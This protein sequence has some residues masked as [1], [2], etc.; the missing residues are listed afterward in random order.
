MKISVPTLLVD[1]RKC[2]IRL[3]Q[4][5]LRLLGCP[6][7][8]QLLVN[9]D[10][11]VI[12]L[13]LCDTSDVRAHHQKR[14]DEALELYSRPLLRQLLLCGC[15]NPAGVYKLYGAAVPEDGVILFKMDQAI[16]ISA[17]QNEK[18]EKSERVCL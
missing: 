1:F 16:M 15:W 17:Q 10:K 13:R 5:T 4:R 14:A 12:A 18:I 9:P 11:R 6:G 7:F 3:H 2:R 8:F